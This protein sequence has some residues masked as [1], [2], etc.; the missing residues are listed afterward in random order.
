MTFTNVFGFLVNSS[1]S[2]TSCVK[3]QWLFHLFWLNVMICHLRQKRVNIFEY[4]KLCQ[5]TESAKDIWSWICFQFLSLSSK[6]SKLNFWNWLNPKLAFLCRLL[7]QT[8]TWWP[9]HPILTSSVTSIMKTMTNQIK[10]WLTFSRTR[11]DLN[12]TGTTINKVEL[13]WM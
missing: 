1:A 7:T 4:L 10:G 12:W 11:L 8:P 3:G 9:N 6:Q 5:M 13:Q 2:W